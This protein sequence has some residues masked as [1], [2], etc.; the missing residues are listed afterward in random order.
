MGDAGKKQD[1]G[2][3]A[4]AT[5]GLKTGPSIARKIAFDVLLRVERAGGYSDELLHEQL[6]QNISPPDAALATELTLGTL[7][8]LRTLDWLIERLLPSPKDRNLRNATP[9]ERLDAEVLISLRLGVYQ[10]RFL[11]RVPARAAVS[12]SVELVKRARKLSAA[13]LVNAVLRRAAEETARGVAIDTL[14]PRDLAP[15]ER[16]GILHS[17][18]TWLVERW[19]GEYGPEKTIALLEADNRAPRISAAVLDPARRADVIRSL[20]KAGLEVRPGRLLRDAISLS[21]GSPSHTAAFERGEIVLLDEASQAVASLLGVQR[22]DSVLD[23]CAAPGGKTALLATAA[24]P[25]AVVVACDLHARRLRTLATL[26][27]RIGVTNVRG[28]VLDGTEPL[29]FAEK[30]QRILVD[31]PCSGTGTLARHPEIRWRLKPGDFAELRAKQIR[32]L[33]NALPLLETGG[34]LVY[35]TCSMEAEENE[36]VVKE[37]LDDVAGFRVRGAGAAIAPLLADGVSAQAIAGSDGALNTSPA[38]TQTDGFY[39]AA[40]ER[41]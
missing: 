3:K 28:V 29:P 18:P 11:E 16:L 13:G 14:V 25:G 41:E 37:V 2:L 33:K 12:E 17:H 40:I 39:A 23:L 15:G 7:R 8:R 10:L 20:E 9:V 36:R 4:S 6:K 31:A 21:G 34:R 32:L 26:M 27:K 24:G 35:S 5:K 30:F 19:L 1:G 38:T 22:G